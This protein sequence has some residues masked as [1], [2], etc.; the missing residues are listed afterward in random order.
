MA[1]WKYQGSP[2][3][4]SKPKSSGAKGPW[5]ACTC[6]NWIWDHRGH[7]QCGRC[8]KDIWPW[9]WGSRSPAGQQPQ[10]PKAVAEDPVKCE[11]IRT[12]I[13]EIEKLHGIDLS[14]MHKKLPPRTTKDP[15]KANEAAL[16]KVLGEARAAEKK[17]ETKLEKTKATV[18][19]AR[20]QLEKANL[21]LATVEA[22]HSEAEGALASAQA[23]YQTHR[24]ASEEEPPGEEVVAEDIDK[25]EEL[26]HEQETKISAEKARIV[27]LR[28]KQVPVSPPFK[29][30]KEAGD[31]STPEETLEAAS[32]AGQKAKESAPAGSA[33]A[34]KADTKE[35]SAMHVG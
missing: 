24:A 5:T 2:S 23:A 28:K 12:A 22:E 32:S 16:F 10:V 3:W 7:S 29:K 34:G 13:A 26:I 20:I 25:L 15:S 27:A 31:S 33:A 8:N 17:S 18:E 30:R 14:D 19:R 4:G 21:E 1:Y 35:N 6:G 9:S 11:A